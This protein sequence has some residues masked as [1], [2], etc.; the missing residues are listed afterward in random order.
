MGE[1]NEAAL[2]DDRATDSV[3]VVMVSYFTG[4]LLFGAIDAVLREEVVARL[5]VVDNGNPAGVRER[6]QQVTENNRRLELISGQG[7]VGFARGCNLGAKRAR[8][9]LLLLLN[10]DCVPGGGEIASLVRAAKGFEGDWLVG[11]RLMDDDGREQAGSRRNTLSPTTLVVEGSGTYRLLPR[12]RRFN[13]HQEPLPEATCEVEVIS[14]ACM[15][16]PRESYNRLGGMDEGY[17]LHVEDIDF[18]LRF[19]QA[20]GRIR[21]CPQVE[22]VHRKGSSEAPSRLV[23][24]H[25]MEGFLRYFR[26]HFFEDTPLPLRIL[27]VSLI[28]LKYS[29]SCVASFAAGLRQRQAPTSSD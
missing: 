9:G 1:K 2:S 22:L 17:F 13:L 12:W 10:P 4:E 8:E 26:R 28:R 25:K 5:V 3:C 27:V 16:M 29:G 11:P 15:L 7:N 18:C 20:G 24:R 14:G 19:R 23:E 6:L 21:F